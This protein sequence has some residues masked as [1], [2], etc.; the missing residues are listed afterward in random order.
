MVSSYLS[1]VACCVVCGCAS[2]NL[3]SS[4]HD[5]ANSRAPTTEVAQPPPTLRQGFDPHAQYNVQGQQQ[6]Q[7][8]DHS[9]MHHG[10]GK[11]PPMDHSQHG[12]NVPT[13]GSNSAAD[14]RCFDSGPRRRGSSKAGSGASAEP[15]PASL[16]E[17]AGEQ[18]SLNHECWLFGSELEQL[19]LSRRRLPGRAKA[20][21][22]THGCR[23]TLEPY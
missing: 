17:R 15:A 20:R 11:S 8:H 12:P 21:R 10:T 16:R 1:L 13:S 4:A 6:H 7:S 22:A 2:R 19:R 9:N 5:P 18:T 23:R 3:E 14:A